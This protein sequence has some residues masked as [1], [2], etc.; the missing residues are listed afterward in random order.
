MG[1]AYRLLL[2]SRARPLDRQVP[3]VE[4]EL[5]Q[6]QLKFVH[7]GASYRIIRIWHDPASTATPIDADAIEC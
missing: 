2:L 1:I 7:A 4:M 5:E 3:A 6:T